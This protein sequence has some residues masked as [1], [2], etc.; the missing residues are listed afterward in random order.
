VA[1][2]DFCKDRK[3]YGHCG[4]VKPDVIDQVREV[5]GLDDQT[6]I[7]VVVRTGLKQL[8]VLKKHGG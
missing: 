6:A 4:R 5:L 7:A 8:L 1:D 2:K 3:V